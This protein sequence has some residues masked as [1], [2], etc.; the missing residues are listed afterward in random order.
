MDR[1]ELA[2][3]ADFTLGRL[4]VLPTR[5]ELVRDDGAREVLENRVMQVLI[6][7]AKPHGKILTRDEL[8]QA[9]WEGRVVGEDAI[10]RVMSRLRGVARGIGTGS[11]AVETVTRIGY[12]LV[13]EGSAAN[14]AVPSA[15]GGPSS[16]A[17]WPTRR[18]AVAGLL[19]AGAAGVAGFLLMRGS[20]PSV[21]PDAAWLMD[22]GWR[23]ITQDTHEGQRQAVGFF[24]RVT[25]I[26]P[27]YPDGWAM[28]GFAY[29]QGAVLGS[30]EEGPAF[31]DRARA[32]S[33]QSLKLDP[34][35]P[36]A[37]LVL[38]F[39]QPQ[40]SPFQL[41]QALRRALARR[42]GND[43]LTSVLAVFLSSVGRFGEAVALFEQV[44]TTPRSA[45]QYF[46]HIQSLWGA[47]RFEAL[48]RLLDSAAELY[49]THANI[50][51]SRF[52]VALHGGRPGAA[53]ALAEDVGGRPAGIPPG[54]FD[55]I[56]AVAKAASSRDPAEIQTVI[57][58]QAGRAREG[59]GMASN[60][61]QFACVLGR[62]D[63]AFAIAEARFFGSGPAVASERPALA[64]NSFSTVEF[65]HVRNRF[66]FQPSTKAMR[67][68]PRFVRLTAKLGLEQYW[69]ECGVGPDYRRG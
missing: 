47:G 1:I 64:H 16:R 4:T 21:P 59:P 5:R 39:T 3:E 52:S 32:A 62:L 31:V 60:A 43:V 23:A 6:A 51:F 15:G 12:R 33:R 20:P 56:I 9:C 44:R 30:R 68:D 19:A 24:R 38:T 35:N 40:L 27:D 25:D 58:T 11:F 8:T 48:D 50:W 57:A 37:A 22:Q 61:V 55:D 65:E 26:S 28:L 66:L 14:A 69:R 42:P 34:E 2:H 53:I 18:T 45:G 54:E 36:L 49:P 41:E 63:E 10:N 17:R 67:G 29:S 46:N 13:A 7:L